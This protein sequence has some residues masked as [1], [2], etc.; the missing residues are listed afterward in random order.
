MTELA[1]GISI[2]GIVMVSIMSVFVFSWRGAHKWQRLMT[3]DYTIRSILSNTVYDIVKHG[4]VSI[5]KDS[6][7]IHVV[8][9]EYIYY[10]YDNMKLYR[11]ENQITSDNVSLDLFEV[12]KTESG[13]TVI[14]R[15]KAMSTTRAGSLHVQLRPS[16]PSPPP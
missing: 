2:W 1:I 11:N 4:N 10:T 3:T 12:R 9:D 16:L 5:Y 14:A 13:V 8:E 6:L 15:A 7:A